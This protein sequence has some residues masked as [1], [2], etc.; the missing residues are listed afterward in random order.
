MNS[1]WMMETELL[2]VW[3]DRADPVPVVKEAGRTETIGECARAFDPPSEDRIP[4]TQHQPRLRPDKKAPRGGMAANLA[5]KVLA[6]K[7]WGETTEVIEPWRFT[8][9][10]R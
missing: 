8:V 2:L 6:D 5:V 10:R 9:S 1:K 4:A 3:Y 7:K